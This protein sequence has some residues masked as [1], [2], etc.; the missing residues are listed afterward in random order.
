MKKPQADWGYENQATGLTSFDFLQD[1]VLDH[2]FP[3]RV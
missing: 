2:H 1:L 3:V